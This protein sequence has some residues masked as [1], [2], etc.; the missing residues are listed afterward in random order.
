MVAQAALGREADYARLNPGH[1]LA[2]KVINNMPFVQVGAVSPDMPNLTLGQREW[3]DRMH[4]EAIGSFM[5]RAV[6][7][8]LR[9]KSAGPQVE[10][11]LC[12]AWTMGFVA[13]VVSDVVIHPIVNLVVG[14]Y[15][16]N[17]DEHRKCEMAQD[18]YIFKKYMKTELVDSEYCRI[19]PPGSA[20]TAVFPFWESVLVDNYPGH[21]QPSTASW[22][23]SYLGLLSV[24]AGLG[25]QV[26][27]VFRHA[28]ASTGYFYEKTTAFRPGDA[29]YFTS[30]RIPGSSAPA[31][32]DQVF[33]RT[34]E[35][36]VA[37]WGQILADLEA[38]DAQNC[39]SYL[40][41]WN[42]DLGVD[43]GRLD[44]WT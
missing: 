6:G 9:L 22:Y 26:P 2:T 7:K 27:A 12:L 43:Q 17:Q 38:G 20:L 21:G 8:L 37:I 40:K 41:D 42:L 32:F 23:E 1:P 4:Y 24:A 16:L 3:A 5:A 15:V 11:D 25:S 44:L 33:A 35:R 36:V 19:L 34:V 10:F 28:G 13:H 39:L 31:D 18:A 30:L 14:P 29:R